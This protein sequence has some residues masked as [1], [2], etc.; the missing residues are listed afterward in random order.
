MASFGPIS[1]LFGADGDLHL[2]NQR[3]TLKKL[4]LIDRICKTVIQRNCL[5]LLQHDAWK[6][7]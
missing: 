6:F 4:V 3:V 5:D 7:K 1:D 2:E